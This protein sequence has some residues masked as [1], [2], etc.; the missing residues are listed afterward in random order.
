MIEW[1]GPI[2]YE[3]RWEEGGLLVTLESRNDMEY[4]L[5]RY[6]KGEGLAFAVSY[7]STMQWGKEVF[8]WD[9]A[10]RRLWAACP[11]TG[12]SSFRPAAQA[13]PPLSASVFEEYSRT[14][15]DAASLRTTL[16]DVFEEHLFPGHCG[17]ALHNPPTPPDADQKSLEVYEIRDSD[18]VPIPGQ[19]FP[20]LFATSHAVVAVVE[21]NSALPVLSEDEARAHP[22]GHL[23]IQGHGGLEPYVLCS[24]DQVRCDREPLARLMTAVD[25][26]MSGHATASASYTVA[27]EGQRMQDSDTY[28]LPPLWTCPALQHKRDEILEVLTGQ[29]TTM[30]VLD[31]C[32]QEDLHACMQTDITAYQQPRGPPVN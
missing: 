19:V 25:I 23:L 17:V 27:V 11:G 15:A 20:V 31:P 32:V 28:S 29:A 12:A 14:S 5:E 22:L 26:I 30:D 24:M 16:A 8:T 10:K 9:V 7:Y 4:V 1:L 18:K 13:P 2:R 21:V 3:L 6:R